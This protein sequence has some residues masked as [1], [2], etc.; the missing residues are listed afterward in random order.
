MV[1]SLMDRKLR[2]ARW[3]PVKHPQVQKQLC[4]EMF[5]N[6]NIFISAREQ[7]HTHAQHA[8]K[9]YYHIHDNFNHSQRE[10]GHSPGIKK[11]S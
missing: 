8:I 10:T 7:I 4:N 11:H 9:G 1:Y 6:I 5:N 2:R 3:V